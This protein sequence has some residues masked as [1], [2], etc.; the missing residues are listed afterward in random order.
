MIIG[1][2][3]SKIFILVILVIF[4]GYS[5]ISVVFSPFTLPVEKF[6]T[7]GTIEENVTF[8]FSG[9][10]S[11]YSLEVI[12][13]NNP[14]GTSISFAITVEIQKIEQ[15]V[16]IPYSSSSVSVNNAWISFSSNETV[17]SYSVTPSKGNL[18]IVFNGLDASYI[19][20][21]TLNLNIIMIPSWNIWI[22]HFASSSQTVSFK[23]PMKF[24]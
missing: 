23:I 4:I 14:I 16:K 24:P 2:R 18:F 3:A 19:G 11:T 22:Y 10:T 21:V 5:A 7:E 9:M 6:K 15:N 8:T 12:A 20:N 1:S 17:K 13:P